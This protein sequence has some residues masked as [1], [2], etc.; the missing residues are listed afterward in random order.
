MSLKW[1][2]L[3]ISRKRK[4]REGKGSG[5]RSRLKKAREP[6]NREKKRFHHLRVAPGP[7][8]QLQFR[9]SLHA[10][11]IKSWQGCVELLDRQHRSE[12]NNTVRDVRMR[13]TLDEICSIKGNVTHVWQQVTN[14]PVTISLLFLSLTARFL[15]KILYLQEKRKIPTND[16]LERVG[17]FRC[18]KSSKVHESTKLSK[19]LRPKIKL[20]LSDQKLLGVIDICF[21]WINYRASIIELLCSRSIFLV[22]AIWTYRFP[23]NFLPLGHPSRLKASSFHAFNRNYNSQ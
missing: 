14:Y 15:F 1:K 23:R 21:I 6:R 3:N 9:F 13:W 16:A 2:S 4:K 11:A 18:L 19:L 10:V 5:K 12:C 7:Q 17:R 20:C 8:S 22:I